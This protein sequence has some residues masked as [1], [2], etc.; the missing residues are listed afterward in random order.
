MEPSDIPSLKA[1]L[2]NQLFLI[3]GATGGET[4]TKAKF[5]HELWNA[6]ASLVQH[7]KDNSLIWSAVRKL[8]R[9]D[10]IPRAF[11]ILSVQYGACSSEP[12][13]IEVLKDFID[14]LDKDLEEELLN[15]CIY[16]EGKKRSFFPE[17]H[18][19]WKN[20]QEV[21]GAA[22]FSCS[23]LPPTPYYAYSLLALNSPNDILHKTRHAKLFGELSVLQ[24]NMQE[25]SKLARGGVR[26][27]FES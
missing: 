23:V 11:L 14:M 7:N 20:I 3:Y 8:E 4:M 16:A 1:G 24:Y 17:L 27:D 15:V 10:L 18:Q 9:G 21:Y 13:K 22:E 2:R 5:L 19:A 12:F 26:P 25:I 6:I